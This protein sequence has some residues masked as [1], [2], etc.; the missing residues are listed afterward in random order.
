MLQVCVN[1]DVLLHSLQVYN[2]RFIMTVGCMKPETTCLMIFHFLLS[3]EQV[4]LLLSL[5]KLTFY[6]I[7]QGLIY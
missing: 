6:L 4:R 5:P 3:V 7:R 1:L 2:A